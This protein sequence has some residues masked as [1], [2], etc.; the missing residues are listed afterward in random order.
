MTT[1]LGT[2]YYYMTF[3]EDSNII[4]RGGLEGLEF[5]KDRAKYVLA[6][7]FYMTSEGMREIEKINEEFKCRNLSPGGCADF[8]ILSLYFYLLEDYID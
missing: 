3:I 5:L 8:L 7:K 4:K 6:N 2:L 1:L